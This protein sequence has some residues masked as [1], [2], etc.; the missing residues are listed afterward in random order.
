MTLWHCTRDAGGTTALSGEM[1][2]A[3]GGVAVS[4][5]ASE[6]SCQTGGK[7]SQELAHGF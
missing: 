1:G 7:A 4:E 3:Q 5:E 6:T 2:K